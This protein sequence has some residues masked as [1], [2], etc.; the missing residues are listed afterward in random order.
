MRF[1]GNETFTDQQLDLYVRTTPNRELLGLPGATWWLWL[2][3]FGSSTVGD[4][5]VGRA[6]MAIGEPPARLDPA[7]LSSD[8]EQLR[9]FY[10]REG[11]REAEVSAG[12]SETDDSTEVEVTFRI[13]EGRPT[14]I[15]RFAYNGLDSLSSAEKGALFSE[16]LIPAGP[17]ADDPVSWRAENRRYSAPLLV[18]EGRRVLAFLRNRG[19]ASVSRDSIHAVVYPVSED[20]FDVT[21]DVRTGRRYRFGD[22]HFEVR[23]PLSTGEERTYGESV[24]ASVDSVAG[25][26]VTAEIANEDVLDFSLLTRSVQF[27][28]GDPYR[29]DLLLA[30]KRR[31]DASGVFAFSDIRR[32][33]VDSLRF[34]QGGR[35]RMN[36]VVDLQTRVRHQI[37]F[38]TFMLQRSGALA[39][40]DNELG[41]G[42]GVTYANLNLFGAGE[43]FRLGTTG[44]IAAD[45][46]GFGGFTSAQWEVNTS[47]TW[48]YLIFP[49]RSLERLATYYDTRTRLSLSLLTA[50]RDALRLVLRSRGSLQYRFELQHNE[51]LTSL[52]DIVDITVSNPDTLDGFR[53]IFLDDVLGSIEDPVQAA[54]LVEDYTRPQFNNALRYTI[55][56]FTSD[57]FRRNFGHSY[58]ASWEA[59]GNLGYALDRFVWSPGEIEGSIPGLGVLGGGGSNRT[60]YRQYVRFAM[61]VRRYM[62]VTARSVLA[63]KGIVGVAHPIGQSNV[64]P[65]DRRFYSGGASSVRA[66]RLRELGPGSATFASEADSLVG[67][68]TNILGGD[69][70]IEAG[71]ELR[72]TVIRSL[73]DADW[74]LA[75]FVD[76]GNVWLGPRNP[77]GP[78]GQFRIDEFP[79]EIG[80]GSGFGLRLA[81][82]FLIVRL[83]AAYKVH[84][85]RRQGELMPDGFSEPVLQ[86]GIGHTF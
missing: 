86:F 22:V 66:W 65:F 55:R 81:W 2:Y 19:F 67:E 51:S 1:S 46:G 28:P 31:L 54:Q 47:L 62:P 3:R 6:F 21:I 11:F 58:E 80:V 68:E 44:S 52:I 70:K 78:R 37:R 32:S 49:M 63:L 16:S 15:R 72:T 26:N 25:G 7:V 40:S 43:A 18:A 56:S 53:E 36:H 39:D 83:D 33:G 60:I 71:V 17:E 29:E 76:A 23:G 59:G 57:P 69:V 4:N 74:I 50:R 27:R 79:G 5:R 14:F 35:L 34:R 61:D 24:E 84:D 20:S 8:V 13:E 12:V 73:L 10:E 9:L 48:P 41:A 45:I 77:G 82:E 85:P 75:L 38:E 30:T 42:A 64:V